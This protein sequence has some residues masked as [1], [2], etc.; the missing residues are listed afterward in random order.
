MS[1][2]TTTHDAPAVPA[3][4]RLSLPIK[5]L[6]GLGSVAFGVKDNGFSYLLLF[7]YSQV[8]GLPATQV[9]LALLIATLWDACIDPL[10]GQISDNTR[11][12]WGRRHPF[13]YA[14][15]IPVALSYAAIW[16]PP[17]WDHG[18][19]FVYLVVS[20][21][22]IRTF[23]SF[24]EVPS[25]ALAAEFSSSYD[26][27]STLLSYRYFF[28]WVGGLAV[29]VAAFAVLLKPDKTHSVGQLNPVGYGHYGV[30]AAIIMFI[31]IVASAAGT[32][33]RIPTLMSPPPKRKLDLAR[34]LRE[35]VAT[36]SNRSYLFLIISG[37]ATAMAGGLSSSLNQYFNTYF[38]GFTAQ[39][40]SLITGS[41]FISA[42]AALNLAPLLSRVFGKRSTAMALIVLSVSIGI[43]PLFLRLAGLMPPNHSLALLITITCT[44]VIGVTFGIVSATMVASMIADVVEASELKTGRR[45]EG[46]LFAASAFIAKSVSG[47]G[48]LAASIVVGFIHLKAGSDPST[49]PPEVPRNLALIY[50]P[51]LTALY[52]VALLLMLGYRITR[53]SHQETLRQLAAQVEEVTQA[54]AA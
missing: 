4:R 43:G 41:V 47:F 15:A 45:S 22:V 17:H 19:L 34:T 44:S 36:L 18:A 1:A 5:L 33:S 48:L 9:G 30:M 14:A 53:E 38:W 31:A 8:V 7:F 28:A 29:Q 12:R 2:S 51:T 6:Y 24:Y 13:M 27:R 39:Q 23:T 10:I 37:L 32:H 20:A 49:V 25:S 40:V 35:M 16:N 46:L 50:A 11:T 3:Q 26:E 52:S 42:I 54:G 21:I